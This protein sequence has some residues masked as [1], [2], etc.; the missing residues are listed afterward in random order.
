MWRDPVAGWD[1]LKS[2]EVYRVSY[3]NG[4]ELADVQD[5]VSL[6]I[7]QSSLIIDYNSLNINV[8]IHE[9]INSLMGSDSS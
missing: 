9:G 7:S 5:H 4:V 3:G 2:S 1:S 8:L 6:L